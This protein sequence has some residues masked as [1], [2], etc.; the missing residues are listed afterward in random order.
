M[1]Q[2]GVNPNA[3]S[4]AVLGDINQRLV[5]RICS[6]CGERVSGQS[7]DVDERVAHRLG[8]QSA[9]LWKTT[10]CDACYGNGF[11]KMTCVPEILT[12]NRSLKEVIASGSTSATL[13]DAAKHNGMLNMAEA[14]AARVYRGETTPHEAHRV[15]PAQQFARLRVTV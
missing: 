14:L 4:Q 5:G 8:D 2:Y 9:E 15:I 10:G 13:E 3:I 6:E 7:P 1:L 11:S 12:I